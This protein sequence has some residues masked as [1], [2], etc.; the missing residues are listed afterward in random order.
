MKKTMYGKCL[1]VLVVL[2]L[3]SQLSVGAI[4]IGDITTEPMEPIVP[5]TSL[6]LPL[7]D[8]PEVLTVEQ[9]VQ[10]QNVARL[11]DEEETQNSAVFRNADGTNTLYLFSENIWYEDANGEKHD[12]NTKLTQGAQAGTF[13]SA[14]AGGNLV[15]PQSVSATTPI[16]YTENGYTVTMYPVHETIGTGAEVMGGEGESR[17]AVAMTEEETARIQ[18]INE[19]AAQAAGKTINAATLDAEANTVEYFRA[20]AD[21]TIIAS[22]LLHGVKNDLLMAS[23]NNVR[24]YSF[25][26]D[27]DGLTPVQS[28]ETSIALVDDEG[29]LQG[30]INVEEI[31][32]ANGNKSF[33]NEI[34][35]LAKADGTY[36]VTMTVDEAFIAEAAY[37]TNAAIVYSSYNYDASCIN[38][39]DVGT[40][41][42]NANYATAAR[43]YVGRLDGEI[44]RSFFQFVIP[45]AYQFAPGAIT[46]AYFMLYEGS[47]NTSSFTI[48]YQVPTYQWDMS[49]MCWNHAAN[50][51]A[52]Y[53]DEFNN[54]EIPTDLTVGTSSMYYA[55]YMS[56]FFRACLRNY[57]DESLPATVNELRGFS[58][59][60]TTES[61]SSP[62]IHLRIFNSTNHSSNKPY[63]TIYYN[64]NFGAA[65][66]YRAVGAGIPPNCMAYAIERTDIKIVFEVG[67]MNST[68]SEWINCVLT[69]MAPYVYSIRSISS[70]TAA[71]NDNEYR[72]GFR[73]A[74]DSV[75][76]IGGGFHVIVQ[77]ADGGWA[78]KNTAAASVNLGHIDPDYGGTENNNAWNSFPDTALATGA[79]PTLYFA[80]ALEAS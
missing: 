45:T 78:H 11:R 13:V 7:A 20:N 48:D 64:N 30:Y 46:D 70:A 28:G 60:L 76:G 65:K 24:E 79:T 6:G 73:G 62:N 39:I 9:T 17:I 61:A 54:V 80:V 53:D 56:P 22:T 58:M 29:Q 75:Y 15:L 40:Y 32:D 26:V 52:M 16:S 37:P 36:L 69:H 67:H 77:T 1:A 38:D 42:P 14:N 23:D 71:I 10:A 68:D 18:A 21:A 5:K 43:L 31:M 72:I 59:R 57:K 27:T 47:T 51:N 25:I 49:A 35:F 55:K 74:R 19:A 4:S 44:Y 2:S 63:L 12:Y 33:Q 41:D 66:A 8:I 34:A 3:L 50:L